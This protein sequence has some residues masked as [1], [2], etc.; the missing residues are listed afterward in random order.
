MTFGNIHSGWSDEIEIL[1]DHLETGSRDRDLTREEH[2]ILDIVE[3][4]Q[5]ITD[6]DG[7]HDFWQSPGDKQ[8]LIKS[9]DLVG[10]T[11]MVDLLNAS[12]WCETRSAERDQYSGIE[13]NHLAEIEEDL[14]AALEELNELMV[15]F[16]EDEG[17]N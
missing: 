17:E 7:L 14:P 12:Q 13:S 6:G 3:S 11:E 5:L 9:F 10:S 1:I 4:V 15:E 2:A 8:R 16:L